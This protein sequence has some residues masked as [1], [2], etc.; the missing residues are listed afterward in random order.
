M[1]RP[2]QIAAMALI[3]ALA[4][5]GCAVVRTLDTASQP[6]TTFEL[7]PLA[8]PGG[9]SGP[10]VLVQTPR[11]TGALATER[12]VIKP[13]A[14]QVTYLPGAQWV[15]P[16]PVHVQSLLVRSIANTG[17]V[18][19]AGSDPSGPLPDFILLTDITEFEAQ[20]LP[21]GGAPAQVVLRLTLTVIRDLDGRIVGSR[22]FTS[23]VTVADLDELTVVSAFD[24]AMTALLDEA[25]GWTIAAM[26]GAPAA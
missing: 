23:T 6:M 13:N 7:T 26:R 22:S 15:D 4:L 21:P 16:T 25:T 18:S 17:R 24:R 12:I 11:A 9:S 2:G 1:I 20:V 5:P 14:L 3:L 10:T 8:G 19:F